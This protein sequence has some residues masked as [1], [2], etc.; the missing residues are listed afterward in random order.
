MARIIRSLWTMVHPQSNGWMIQL[1]QSYSY[2][3]R[4]YIYIA[5]TIVKLSFW[6]GN[7]PGSC[8]IHM[9]LVLDPNQNHV[10]SRP[11]DLETSPQNEGGYTL[12]SCKKKA[13]VQYGQNS[14]VP[15]SLIEVSSPILG[16]GPSRWAGQTVPVE[17]CL[18]QVQED[19]DHTQILINLL[20]S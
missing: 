8:G 7:G 14:K 19:T 3:G 9:G 2:G 13:R 6:A 12:R 5:F 11:S 15:F 17:W 1:Y 20:I 18:I 16:F 4:A 10:W